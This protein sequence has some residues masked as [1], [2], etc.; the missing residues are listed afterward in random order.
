MVTCPT[1][2]G[3]GK[4]QHLPRVPLTPRQRQILDAIEQHL[5]A[6]RVAPSQQELADATGLRS[7]ASVH[8]HLQTLHRKGY[9][10]IDYNMPRGITVLGAAE[11]TA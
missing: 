2:H 5:A 9:I 1:C 8:E 7:L 10:R 3:T 4:V 11:S 6:H